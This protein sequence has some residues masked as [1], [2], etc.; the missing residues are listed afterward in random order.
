MLRSLIKFPGKLETN[1]GSGSSLSELDLERK[2]EKFKSSIKA[3]V[4]MS[5]PPKQVQI[6]N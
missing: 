5:L 1:S 4:V 3:V 2:V 6:I